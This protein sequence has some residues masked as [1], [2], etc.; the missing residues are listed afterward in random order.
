MNS[1]IITVTTDFGITDPWTA[2]MKGVML[3]INGRANIVDISNSVPRCDIKCAGY[4]LG[5]CVPWF[6]RGTVHLA[7]VDPEVGGARRAI[8]VQGENH[9]YV[10]PDNGIFTLALRRDK[11]VGAVEIQPGKWTL[12]NISKTFEGRDVFA[13]VAAHL[14]NGVS[15]E[16]LGTEIK[17]EDLTTLELPGNELHGG[18]L[19][20]SVLHI[21]NFG[22]LITML[23]VG[24]LDRPVLSVKIGE[25][26]IPMKSTYSDV[27]DGEALAYWGS[28]GFC[29]I[30]VNKGSAA[31]ELGVKSGDVLEIKLGR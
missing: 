2:I 4:L 26:V 17:R 19:R 21:D 9:F 11:F 15:L 8:A 6:P 25:R 10:G 14:S 5:S 30:A 29:E 22:N 13:P 1:G 24:D 16:T 3:R 23:H 27:R 18:L 31:E 20:T 12:D 7:V 28:S